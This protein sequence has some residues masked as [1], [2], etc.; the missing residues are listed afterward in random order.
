[1]LL[2]YNLIIM[3]DHSERMARRS[4]IED[5][6]NCEIAYRDFARAT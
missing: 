3:E 6:K 4:N 5:T 1:M 2:N